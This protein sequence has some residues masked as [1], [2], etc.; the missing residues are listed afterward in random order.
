[1]T[2]EAG[3]RPVL[4][5][6]IEALL[7]VTD[8]PLSVGEIC[9]ALANEDVEPAVVE[10]ALARLVDRYAGGASE[11]RGFELVASGDGWQF[12]TAS[13]VTP[14]LAEFTGLRPVRLSR[15]AL[16]TLAIVAYR[17]PCTR[18][19]VERVRSVDSG[20]ILRALLDRRLLR[21]AGRRNEPGRPNVYATSQEFLDVF[22]LTS[23]REMPNLREFTMLGEEDMDAVTALFGEE[24]LN[25]VTMEEFA[26]RRAVAAG[27]GPTPGLEPVPGEGAQLET[28]PP[29]P[30][31]EAPDPPG[32]PNPAEAPDLADA[33][34]DLQPPDDTA[35]AVGDAP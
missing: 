31:A 16:E 30:P 4:V 13:E 8:K 32:A 10:G 35:A 19:E 1:M 26:Q 24:A 29:A 9:Q 3:I 21:L 5:A 25:Q 15:A 28:I 12:R 33:P 20:G 27:E 6:V 17:Q 11:G 14:W 22:G 34:I 23:I 7:F 18:A 2:E